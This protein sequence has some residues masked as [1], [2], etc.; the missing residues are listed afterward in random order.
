MLFRSL[1]MLDREELD[2]VIIATPDHWHARMAIDAARRGIHIYLEK[3]MTR[4]LE[5]AFAVRDAVR[6][7]GVV[8]QLGHQGRQRDLNH[9]AKELIAK[10]T[11]GEISL[12]ETTTN[13]NDAPTD[14]S[15]GWEGRM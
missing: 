7:S 10:G 3:C 12:V 8:F 9:K 2:A 14:W 13:R 11:L 6:K 1:D 15:F 4:T 5:E